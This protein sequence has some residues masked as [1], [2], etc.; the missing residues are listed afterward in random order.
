MRIS[1]ARSSFEN[2]FLQRKREIFR[3]NFQ[4]KILENGLL[5]VYEES[6]IG[7]N[8]EKMRLVPAPH[9][10]MGINEMDPQR[11]QLTE[12]RAEETLVSSAITE[13]IYGR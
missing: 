2:L 9:Q 6:V 7:K 12:T 13:Q 11:S 3:V 5:T 8:G 4:I 1:H 10:L